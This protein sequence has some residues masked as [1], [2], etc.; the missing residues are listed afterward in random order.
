MPYARSLS[1]VTR[2]EVSHRAATVLADR[3]DQM[4]VG[5]TSIC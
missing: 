2:T 5:S 1:A 4:P 3:G